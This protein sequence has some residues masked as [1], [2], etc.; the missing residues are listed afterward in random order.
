MGPTGILWALMN[1][2]TADGSKI[3][4]K[5]LMK[6]LRSR[7][8]DV[9]HSTCL[10]AVAQAAGYANWGELTRLIHDE[11]VDDWSNEI[12]QNALLARAPALDPLAIKDAL[13]ALHER[14]GH[15]T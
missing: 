11:G 10:E 7:G 15:W 3:L 4:A 9:K 8:Q 12:R 1:A 2:D 13:D 5:N 14:F 6:E